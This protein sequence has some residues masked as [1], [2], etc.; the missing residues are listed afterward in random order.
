MRNALK[1]RIVVR[2][3][4]L[5]FFSYED[6]DFWTQLLYISYFINFSNTFFLKLQPN[7][8]YNPR[9]VTSAACKR[10]GSD[11]ELDLDIFIR[12]TFIPS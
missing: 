4:L 12:F 7:I 9:L 8:L 6:Y 1:S 3:N 10:D 5:Q 11:F 2:M